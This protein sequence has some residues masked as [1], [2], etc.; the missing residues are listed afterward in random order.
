MIIFT[1]EAFS[2]LIRSLHSVVNRTPQR[3]LKEIILV[4]DFST[5]RDLKGKL[6]RYLATRFPRGK[7][8]LLRIQKRAGLIIA[9]MIGAHVAQGDV[10]VFLDAHIETIQSW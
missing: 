5:R 7:I 2:S 10:L 3:H 8:R 9:R 1:D 6:E 4:D